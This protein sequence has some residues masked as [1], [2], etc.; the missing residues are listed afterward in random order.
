MAS[1]ILAIRV[2]QGLV[3]EFESLLVKRIERKIDGLGILE[4]GKRVK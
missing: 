1:R 3:V 4:W 2:Y